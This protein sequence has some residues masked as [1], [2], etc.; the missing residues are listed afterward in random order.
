MIEQ[1]ATAGETHLAFDTTIVQQV[2]L[3]P[4]G[5]SA[6]VTR[7]MSAK[8]WADPIQWTL[9]VMHR[10]D[11]LLYRTGDDGYDEE[12]MEILSGLT[13]NCADALECKQWWAHERL[14]QPGLHHADGSD[15]LGTGF[16]E[17]AEAGYQAL[18]YD[19]EESA[20]R[21]RELKAYYEDRPMTTV[22]FPG[23]AMSG[24]ELLVYDPVTRRLI[25]VF[26]P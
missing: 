6:T 3:L 8:T 1:T 21:A 9:V 5:S 16:N 26:A 23:N 18:G 19:T 20:Q 2:P 10:S 7:S 14:L 17:M 22:Y 12:I 11:T 24:Y 25:P 13:E 15:A 4:D